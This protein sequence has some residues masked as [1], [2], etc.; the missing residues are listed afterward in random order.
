[1][2][3][4]IWICAVYKSLSLSPVAVKE[5]SL[6]IHVYRHCPANFIASAQQTSPDTFASS[7]DQNETNRLIRIYTVC[8]SVIDFSLKPLVFATMDVS[9]LETEQPILETQGWK[10]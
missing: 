4:L 6:I 7:A 9:E 3:R 5:L 1:M 8:H 2:N 10:G